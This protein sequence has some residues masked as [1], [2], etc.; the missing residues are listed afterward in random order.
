MGDKTVH[1]GVKQMRQDL[2]IAF[3]DEGDR[4]MQ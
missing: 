3:L 1:G 2:L 4:L